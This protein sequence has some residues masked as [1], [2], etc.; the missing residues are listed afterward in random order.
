MEAVKKTIKRKL[1]KRTPDIRDIVA[2]KIDS[3]E[4]DNSVTLRSYT[5]SPSTLQKVI[6]AKTMTIGDIQSELKK[7]I[8][9]KLPYNVIYLVRNNRETINEEINSGKNSEIIDLVNE[10]AD[11]K[12]GS[13]GKTAY[14]IAEDKDN[15]EFLEVVDNAREKKK[16]FSV[17]Q[18]ADANL[19]QKQQIVPQSVAPRVINLNRRMSRTLNDLTKVER[20]EM[21]KLLSKSSP[22]IGI[23]K[24]GEQDDK[25]VMPNA[26]EATDEDGETLQDIAETTD[27]KGTELHWPGGNDLQS[28]ID[29]D[30]LKLILIDGVTQAVPLALS[31]SPVRPSLPDN[32]ADSGIYSPGSSPKKAQ[33]SLEESVELLTSRSSSLSLSIE[34]LNSGDDEEIS[35]LSRTEGVIKP[36]CH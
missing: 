13:K 5:G 36:H 15:K 26:L 29:R 18:K 35:D 9:K 24:G 32:D 23:N 27:H 12:A 34:S 1:S 14:Q 20:S 25:T 17:S 22:S 16:I 4:G 8:K 2:S 30:D 33:D 6:A 10:A 11:I 31:Q 7:A 21:S 3:G 19:P 28:S